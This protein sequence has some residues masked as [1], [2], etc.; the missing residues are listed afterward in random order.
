MNV[1]PTADQGVKGLGTST[2]TLDADAMS[3]E[4]A[5]VVNVCSVAPP[6]A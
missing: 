6:C 5:G 3:V 4:F 1:I 2:E